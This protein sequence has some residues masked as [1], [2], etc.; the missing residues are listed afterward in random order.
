MPNYAIFRFEKHKTVGTIKAASLHMTRGRETQNADPDRK[1]LNEILK[2]STDPSADVKSMLNKIQKE[3]GK[4]LRKNGV[5]AIELFFGMSPEWS[6]QATPE[7]LE[8]WKTITQQWAEQTFGENNLVSLQLHAD[9][10]TPH[11][12]G[13]MVPRDPDTGRL[14]ASRWFDGRKA[15]S[16]LQTSYA[17]SMEP[18]GLARGVKGSKA[19]H[20]RVQR[21]YGNINKTLQL[22]PK[23]QAP[24]PPSIFT[25]KEEWAEKERLKAQKSALSVIQPLADKAARYVEE[26]KRADR[27]EEA[28]SLAR[29]KADSMRA[30]PLSD[31]LKTLGMELDPAD[32]KQWRDPEHRFRITIDNYKFYDHSAQKGGGGAID[33]LM[34]TTGQDYKGAL[35]WLAD[36]FGDETA[37]HDM[38][39]ND[40]YR[41]KIRINE[42]K[43]RPAFK[44]PEHKNEPKIREFLNSRGI[45]FNN[46]PDSIRTDD[47]GNVAFLMYDDKDTLQGAELRGTSSGF[48][49]LALGSSRESH[50]TGSI[51]VKNDEKYDL[52]IAE[53]AIDAISV[54]GFL[55]PE[56]I[57]AGVKLLSTSGVR[58]SLTKTLR[59]IVE[60]ASS[61]H[62]AYDWDAVGQRA[63]SL[64]VGAIKAA[65][66]TKKV[67]NWLPPKEQMIH[68][69]DWNDLLMVKRGL[70]KTVAPKQTVKRKIRF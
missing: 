30:I 66:P 19:T 10:T 13:F 62:I 25:N 3:T 20:Q 8:H 65:F 39:L 22:D 70:K 14:N 51:N 67:E 16:A 33:L 35:S 9:E 54:V 69:K 56:K 28:L 36:R 37:R 44:Q 4:P 29:R 42:A 11:L 47:R 17:A 24:I 27:A 38:L 68:G 57:K 32:K 58:T 45:S 59:K 7:K 15:L 40:L 41:S 21:H 49:G 23:I 60:K 12:T 64:L 34:H 43:Q 48:K 63:A 46:I 52:Y 6:K 50:F 2:G 55:S 26:K 18:L 53:S 1:E 5:Q 61:V 31:V